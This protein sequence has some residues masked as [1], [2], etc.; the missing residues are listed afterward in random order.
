MI[1]LKKITDLINLRVGQTYTEK[2]AVFIDVPPDNCFRARHIVFKPMSKGLIDHLIE[3]Y[4]GT[5]P[6]SLLMLYRTMNGALLFRTMRYIEAA[7]LYIPVCNF[8]VY[9]IPL[10][11]PKGAIEPFNI[12]IEDLNRPYGIPDHWLKFGSYYMPDSFSC[13]CDLYIDTYTF[14]VHGIDHDS[15]ECIDLY[16]WQSLDECLCD[17]FDLLSANSK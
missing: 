4:K 9:G 11:E 17:I 8:S 6:E 1:F 15:C 12:S 10:G 14:T 16:Q 13:K 7:N 2:N 3:S 5:I